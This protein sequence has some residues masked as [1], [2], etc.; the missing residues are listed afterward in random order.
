M[1]PTAGARPDAGQG[2]GVD[3]VAEHGHGHVHGSA[4][5]LLL[6]ALGVVFG[7]IG[8]SPLYA[9]QTALGAVT[10]HGRLPSEGDVLG[11]VSL[12]I[13][14]LILI[15][16]VKYVA[17]V[18]RADNEGEGGIL[19]LLSLV[20]PPNA[21]EMVPMVVFLGICGAA[22]LFGDGAITP[23][24]S[25]LSAM[26]G[27][28]VVDKHL[29]AAVLPLT[30]AVLIGLFAIQHRGTGVIGRL[31]GPVMA[32]WFTVLAGMGFYHVAQR[33]DILMAFNPLS[34]EHLLVHA[35]G[36]AFA[37]FGAVFLALTGA[38][39][40]YADM[41]H[42]GAGPIR[43]AWFVIVFPALV[44]NYLG[45]GALLLD[46]PGRVDTPSTAWRRKWRWCAGHPG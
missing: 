28:G 19:S 25:V 44:L 40:L 12:I 17:L 33:P 20:H 37:V 31:F 6:G 5:A 7:D 1:E 35:P 38:E 32:L 34:A 16:A 9:M 18:L 15:V 29:A 41:G 43:R 22:L 36:V 39:A 23:A 45:Q 8:T 27:L 42:F 11:V 10:H 4:G 3:G 14:A 24:I 21:K 46:R 26:E 13:W 30:V 2:A